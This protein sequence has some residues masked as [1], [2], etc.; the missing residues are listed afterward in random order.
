VARIRSDI[1]C[2]SVARCS[3]TPMSARATSNDR[4]ETTRAAMSTL[5]LGTCFGTG[6]AGRATSR[7]AR[8]TAM[9]SSRFRRLRPST[10]LVR[11]NLASSNSLAGPTLSTPCRQSVRP[12]Y[13][14]PTKVEPEGWAPPLPSCH[15]PSE[16]PNH[17]L[18]AHRSSSGRAQTCG[19]FTRPGENAS[20]ARASDRFRSLG[21]SAREEGLGRELE[22]GHPVG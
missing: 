14:S 2:S 22:R 6:G 17:A 21:S 4:A 8:C 15:R 13:F 3:I 11:A 7:A 12:R 5:N 10:P 16:S 18:D 20:Q 19:R 9:S 1:R